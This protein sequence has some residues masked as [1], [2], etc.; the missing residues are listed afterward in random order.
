MEIKGTTSVEAIR[1]VANQPQSEAVSRPSQPVS[2]STADTSRMAE[3]ARAVQEKSGLLHAVRLAKIE[4]AIRAGS[5]QPSASQ[6]ASRL[7]DAAE[8]DEH[9]QAIL[10]G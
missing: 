5:Y 4:K 2:V 9:L 7:L 10:R 3:M 1:S 8:I 6:I